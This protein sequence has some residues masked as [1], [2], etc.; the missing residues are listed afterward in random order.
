MI[1]IRTERPEDAAAISALT[2]AAFLN[3]PHSSHQEAAVVEALRAGGALALSLVADVRGAVA[4]HIAFSP[5]TIDGRDI[6]WFGLGP[7][8]VDPAHQQGGIGLALV[9][10]GLDT[11]RRNG[12]QG[13]VVL[14]DPA[15]YGRFG[16]RAVRGLVLPGPPAAFFQAL[17]LGGPM[18]Q[19]TVAYYPAFA[20]A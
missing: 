2:S 4:G 3:A 20:A 1:S 9:R 12:A 17:A 19:G 14:G 8:S 13:C 6:G 7:V 11:L 18:A 16:F 15:Y 5:V 10:Q